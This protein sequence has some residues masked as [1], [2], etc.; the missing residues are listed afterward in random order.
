MG[1]EDK[2][3]EGRAEGVRRSENSPIKSAI[4]SVFSLVSL[5]PRHRARSLFLRAQ[6]ASPLFFPLV[7]ENVHGRNPRRYHGTASNSGFVNRFTR[8]PSPPAR[9]ACFNNTRG[10]LL[11]C[12]GNISQSGRVPG[13]APSY[14]EPGRIHRTL[15]TR[16]INEES[17]LELPSRLESPT[18]TLV[19]PSHRV[20]RTRSQPALGEQ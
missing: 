4:P 1:N 7:V 5:S 14:F 9:D 12:A 17:A 8:V 10:G 19:A 3:A 18:M 13:I 15:D 16:F 11:P 2:S 20:T 6:I